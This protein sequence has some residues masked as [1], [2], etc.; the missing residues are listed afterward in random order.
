MFDQITK[1]LAVSRL[2]SYADFVIIPGFF[3]FT[4]RTNTGAAWSMFSDRP[5]ALAFFATAVAVGLAVWGYRIR[6]EEQLLRF[7]LA[8]I[9]GG[10][11]GNLADR[12]RLGHVVDFIDFHW[13]E[14]YHF[15]T[16]NVADTSIFVGMS[17]LIFMSLRTPEAQAEREESAGKAAAR[18][19]TANPQS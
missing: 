8:L 13:R 6:P 3:Q 18:T 1:W 17:I 2:A 7:P 9:L 10:A 4:Y 14:V 12:W 16:F 5:T 11:I 15:P 19:E